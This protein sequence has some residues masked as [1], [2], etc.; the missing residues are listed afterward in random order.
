MSSCEAH[1][2][3]SVGNVDIDDD[4]Y[5][6]MLDVIPEAGVLQDIIDEIMSPRT[7]VSLLQRVGSKQAIITMEQDSGNDRFSVYFT[8][9]H[10]LEATDNMKIS[11]SGE[12][13]SNMDEAKD[14]VAEKV[15]TFL[16]IL[17][18]ERFAYSGFCERVLGTAWD[19]IRAI[20]FIAHY[21]L[22]RWL[23]EDS[24]YPWK[25]CTPLGAL[26][27]T[28]W[29]EELQTR[30]EMSSHSTLGVASSNSKRPASSG[31][32]LLAE[33][34]GAGQQ[35]ADCEPVHP[36]KKMKYFLGEANQP[37][38]QLSG[39]LTA[40]SSSPAPQQFFGNPAAN[41][42]PAKRQRT[43]SQEL[44]S[45]SSGPSSSSSQDL[46]ESEV[47]GQGR[48]ERQG[49]I[50]LGATAYEPSNAT[51][52]SVH[53]NRA[54]PNSIASCPSRITLEALHLAP[55][56]FGIALERM[57]EDQHRQQQTASCQA[58]K[59]NGIPGTSFS[60][61]LGTLAREQLVQQAWHTGVGAASLA[62]GGPPKKPPPPLPRPKPKLN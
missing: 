7:K 60:S 61:N 19:R 53:N 10:P 56:R 1:K 29:Y 2:P 50:R 62:A 51:A 42:P 33:S 37:P 4:M 49:S 52:S 14:V 45:S 40:K 16:L 8:V 31:Q 36:R 47:A 11:A 55:N 35:R 23:E 58:A 15:L 20:A 9:E 32:T 5:G 59:V 30:P 57:V 48:E 26:L 3:D 41:A 13:F 24:R 44:A 46:E 27:R 25:P 6:M 18:P 38:Q 43:R 21:A 28:T 39:N 54:A 34:E 22:C 17:F 12:H